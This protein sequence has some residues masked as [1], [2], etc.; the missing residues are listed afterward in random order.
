M[1]AIAKRFGIGVSTV[2]RHVRRHGWSR[3]DVSDLPVLELAQLRVLAGKLRERLEALIDDGSY[4]QGG[5]TTGS[6]ENPANLLLK[7]CQITEKITNMESRMAGPEVPT[8]ARLSE[9]DHEILERFKNRYGQ[10]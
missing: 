4:I 6:Q 10:S 9:Q 3:K 2:H 5:K 1:I 7:L 8:A